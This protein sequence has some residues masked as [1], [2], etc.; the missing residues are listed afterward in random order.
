MA[1]LTAS[2]LSN[3]AKKPFTINEQIKLIHDFLDVSFAAC[4][5]T[6]GSG[7]DRGREVCRC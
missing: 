1:G 3:F 2:F 7:K 4:E 5:E 6:L